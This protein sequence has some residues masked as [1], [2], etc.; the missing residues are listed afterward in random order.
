MPSI[1]EPGEIEAAA[2]S[3]P[4]LHLPP[5]NLFTLRAERLERLAE[6]HPLAEYLRLIAGLC[7]AQQQVLDDP[8]STGPVDQQRLALCQQHGLPPFGADTLIREDDW[9]AWL[10]ALLQRYA[11]RRNP[12]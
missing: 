10:A 2:S 8:P 1:L 11:P 5:H 4:F 7:R 3:P 9:Q 12:P 6:G